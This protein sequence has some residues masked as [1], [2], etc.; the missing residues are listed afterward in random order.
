MWYNI[1][2]GGNMNRNS[3]EY[4][5]K[6]YWQKYLNQ[7]KGEKLD[8]LDDLW[9][10]KYSDIFNTIPKGKAIDLGCGLGQYTDYL[11]SKGFDVISCDIS[12]EALVVLK[13]RNPKAN[14]LELDMTTRL[15][16]EDNSIKLVFANLSIHYFDEVTTKK[17]LDEIERI[18]DKD[19]YFVGSVNSSKALEK[20]KDKL[21][22][23]EP[24]YYLID[25]KY[26]R[27]FDR[28]QF[29]IFFK[30]YDLLILE[31]VITTRWNRTKIQWE[32]IAKPKK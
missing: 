29:D 16:F 28:K 22:M 3:K 6:D 19:G 4:W 11:I 32:F 17:L 8:F 30:N 31:E 25:G 2:V 21:V 20:N 1:V 13:N 5:N 23:I 14:I 15:P 10:E 24:N 27:Y 12:S 18:L 26:G 7:N 9:M